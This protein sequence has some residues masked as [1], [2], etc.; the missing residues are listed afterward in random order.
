MLKI[1]AEKMGELEK[2]GYREDGNCYTK[3]VT[4]EREIFIWKDSREIAD[5]VIDPT[6]YTG[7][8]YRGEYK[9]ILKPYIQD[10]IK[11]D[12]VEVCDD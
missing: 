6:T 8:K 4:R 2:F 12:M 11:A 1:K 9:S 7:Y 3:Q 10:L 5:Y